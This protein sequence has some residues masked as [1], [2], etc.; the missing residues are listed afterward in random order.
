MEN[1]YLKIRFASVFERDRKMWT[2]ILL[3]GFLILSTYAQPCVK[4]ALTITT[5]DATDEITADAKIRISGITDANYRVG[6]VQG[7]AYDPTGPAFT[8]LTA[9]STMYTNGFVESA[10]PAPTA[11]PGTEYTVRVYATATCFKDSTFYLPYVNYNNAPTY[12]DLVT[13]VS[14]GVVGDL[15]LGKRDTIRVVIGNVGTEDATGVDLQVSSASGLQLISS[16]APAGTSFNSTTGLWTVGN[17]PMA[18]NR[19]LILV[20]QINTRGIKEV[21]AEVVAMD[22][23]DLNSTDNPNDPAVENDEGQVCIS[24]HFDFCDGD[25][26]KFELA[27]NRYKDVVWQKYNGSTWV[28]ITGSTPEYTIGADSVLVIKSAGDYRYLKPQV[29]TSCAYVACCPVKVIPGLPPKL[30]NPNVE[31]ICF[32]QAPPEI[33]ATNTQTG[34]SPTDHTLWSI[35]DAP[36]NIPITGFLPDQG[37]FKYQWYNNNGPSNPT[38]TPI[39]G[40]DSLVLKTLPTATGV[41]NY[42]LI[43]VQ[44]GHESCRDTVEVVYTINEIPVA[45]ASSNSP[46][47]A[48]DTIELFSRNDALNNSINPYPATSYQW[49]GPATFAS[50]DSATTRLMATEAM[51]GEYFL[52]AFYTSHGQ[53]C[54]DTTSIQVVINPLPDKPDA[55]DIALCNFIDSQ[56]L[57]AILSV[58]V[59][60]HTGDSLRWYEASGLSDVYRITDKPDTSTVIGMNV[61]PW[62]NTSAA[63]GQYKWWVTTVDNLGCQSH[64]D[65]VIITIKA[66]PLPPVVRDI[67]F[68]QNFPTQRLTAQ[69]STGSVHKLIWYGEDKSVIPGDTIPT[70]TAPESDSVGIFTYW[71]SQY[72]STSQCQSDTANFDVHIKDTPDGPGVTEPTYCLGDVPNPLIATPVVTNTVSGALN[73]LTWYWNGGTQPTPP[74]PTTTLAGATWAYVSQTTLYD[75]LSCESPQSPL[76]ITVNPLPIAT[77]ISVSS[78]CIGNVSQNNAKLILNRFRDSEEVAYNAGPSFTAPGTFNSIPANGEFT[79]DLPNA[80]QAYMVRVKNFHPGPLGPKQFECFFDI[81]ATITAKDCTCPGGYCE[82]AIVT[83]SK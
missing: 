54:S 44:D 65:S 64:I 2:Q 9:Y 31:V 12:V 76:K 35:P 70:F 60:D 39:A 51:E 27:N 3:L 10:L 52:R 29:G 16:D 83:K 55:Q 56:R 34:Y 28:T 7:G 50:T 19:T 48:E 73:T 68:C 14:K 23:I 36:M 45:F 4:P 22:Q 21:E 69:T 57:S 77:V 58:P 74:T 11:I 41:Y 30:T 17:V 82:P 59:I 5:Y 81:P 62:A 53:E 40:S 18:T 38:V 61:G 66:K 20:Y 13:T 71:V 78:L 8:A 1:N 25:E 37:V 43:S 63:P 42:R 75:T 49:W 47:C 67:A 26:F 72:D 80:D 6:I 15:P 24:S 33:K 46:I 79:P 32:G